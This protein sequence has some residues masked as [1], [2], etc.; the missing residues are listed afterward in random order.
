MT[1]HKIIKAALADPEK[2]ESLYGYKPNNRV[3]YLLVYDPFQCF[4]TGDD[5]ERY[6]LPSMKE[7]YSNLGQLKKGLLWSNRPGV[8][9]DLESV[10]M[11]FDSDAALELVIRNGM[12]LSHRYPDY[13]PN[14]TIETFIR[15]N[16]QLHTNWM[17]GSTCIQP[18]KDSNCSA[19]EFLKAYVTWEVPSSYDRIFKDMATAHAFQ[20]MREYDEVEGSK[21]LKHKAVEKTWKK[22]GKMLAELRGIQLETL[23][24]ELEEH[25][26]ELETHQKKL[27]KARK[28]LVHL[29]LKALFCSG[30]VNSPW[31]DDDTRSML[32]PPRQNN[33]NCCV[34]S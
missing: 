16:L 25:Q 1:N 12:A 5:N 28:N 2:H 17:T 24:K 33:F 29:E 26:K 7:F 10:C 19:A 34:I 18:N 32:P 11:D 6:K 8:L 30:L 13:S 4:P 14:E 15:R 9:P 3:D 22:K 27:T 21:G 20:R 23:Q 31:S